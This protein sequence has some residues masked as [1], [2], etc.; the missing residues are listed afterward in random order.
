MVDAL[1]RC[2]LRVFPKLGRVQKRKGLGA[3]SYANF[4][5]LPARTFNTPD[6]NNGLYAC[7]SID[8]NSVC[9][10][11]AVFPISLEYYSPCYSS[12]ISHQPNVMFACMKPRDTQLPSVQE[13]AF[14]FIVMG[15]CEIYTLGTLTYTVTPPPRDHL[16]HY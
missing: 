6:S 7:G 12:A 14:F 3:L 16:V 2:V 10:S 9:A 13:K 8:E 4:T 15:S 5:N 1:L 11:N